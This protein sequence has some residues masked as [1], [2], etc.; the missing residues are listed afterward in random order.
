MLSFHVA[1]K[2]PYFKAVPST[3][4]TQGRDTILFSPLDSALVWHSLLTSAIHHVFINSN[5]GL[6]YLRRK[7]SLCISP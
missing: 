6:C 1:L 2:L 5:K 7:I 3:A 4:Q